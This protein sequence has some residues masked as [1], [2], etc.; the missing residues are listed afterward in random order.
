MGTTR[1]ISEATAQRIDQEVR[2]IL[3]EAHATA[4]QILQGNKDSL[5]QLAQALLEY[6]TLTGDE[7]DALL[8]DKAWKK[9]EP[10]IPGKS[11]SKAG[12]TDVTKS[13]KKPKKTASKKEPVEDSNALSSDT[14]E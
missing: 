12:L 14:K 7:I 5:H 11:R 4:S 3:D 2:R 6:E 13:V 8:K 1:N 9:P 10:K